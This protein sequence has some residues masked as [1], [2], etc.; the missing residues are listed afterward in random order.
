M[1]A[2][3]QLIGNVTTVTVV[4]PTGEELVCDPVCEPVNPSD[5]VTKESKDCSSQI[6]GILFLFFL[7]SLR[8]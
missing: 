2:C 6:L 1:V 5:H 8:P 3:V 7:K 4:L